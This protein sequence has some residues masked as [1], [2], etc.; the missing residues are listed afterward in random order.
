MSWDERA[1]C[2]GEDTETFFV[3]EQDLERVAEARYICRACPVT[4]ECLAAAMAEEAGKSISHRHGIRGG[5]TAS[6]RWEMA[7]A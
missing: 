3:F 7:G 6:E 5:V 1:L 4:A 2:H